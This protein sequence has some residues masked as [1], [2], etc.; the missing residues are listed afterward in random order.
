MTCA[1]DNYGDRHEHFTGRSAAEREVL[2]HEASVGALENAAKRRG[3]LLCAIWC[4]PSFAPTSRRSANATPFLR[5]MRFE[6]SG[7]AEKPFSWRARRGAPIA[8][9]GAGGRALWRSS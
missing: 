7:G 9:K 3:L 1:A 4:M 8:S 2:F 5:G 6:S